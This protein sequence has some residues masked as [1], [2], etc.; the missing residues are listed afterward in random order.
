MNGC[1]TKSYGEK[2]VFEKFCFAFDEGEITCVLG[3][4]GVGKTTLLHILAGQTGF[5]GELLGVPSEVGYIF[6]EPRLLP[7][8]TIAQNLAFTGGEVSAMENLL[9]KIG[10]YEYKDKKAGRLSGGEKQRVAIARAFLSGR[11]LVLMDE[12]FSALDIPL[13][14]R[15]WQVF[16][17]LWRE[18][19]PTVVLVTH[20]IDEAFALG[21]RVVYL[22][23]GAIAY[24]CKV[25]RLG[26]EVEYGAYS[27][28]KQAFLDWLLKREG[29]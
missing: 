9:K 26:G 6:Q 16:D 1:I 3:P 10:L 19:K 12:P 22:E 5:D 21:H 15:L 20:D 28:Q 4:S 27:A 24:D 17:E 23:K 25:E 8:L 11:K 14:V 18:E 2:K 13:K 7:N 29:K